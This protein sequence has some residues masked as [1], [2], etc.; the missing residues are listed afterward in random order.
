MGKHVIKIDTHTKIFDA[1]T[2]SCY[3]ACISKL[4]IG[5]LPLFK[6]TFAIFLFEC[7]FERLSPNNFTTM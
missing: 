7:A 1:P 4:F 3:P 6:R 2:K 5:I